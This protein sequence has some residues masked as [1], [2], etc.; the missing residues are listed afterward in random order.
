MNG[1]GMKGL[2]GIDH[3]ESRGQRHLGPPENRN[4]NC[5]QFGKRKVMVLRG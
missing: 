2:S 4:G 1:G 5:G 3:V